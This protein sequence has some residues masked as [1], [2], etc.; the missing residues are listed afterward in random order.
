MVDAAQAVILASGTLAPLGSL[1]QQLFPQPRKPLHAFAC[2]HIVPPSSVLALRL[3]QG[4]SGMALDLR[5]G[6]RADPALLKELLA[7]LLG[8][9]EATPQVTTGYAGSGRQLK[10][11]RCWLA[12]CIGAMAGIAA[13]CISTASGPSWC[14]GQATGQAADSPAG[15]LPIRIASILCDSDML[16]CGACSSWAGACWQAGPTSLLT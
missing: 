12:N 5:H 11:G 3:P 4:P 9:C 16:C 15:H 6:S 13:W 7:A 14:H 1:C 2:G 10:L 8:I